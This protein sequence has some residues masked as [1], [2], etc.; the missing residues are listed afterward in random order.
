MAL[1]IATENPT[2]SI[3]TSAAVPTPRSGGIDSCPVIKD[4]TPVA[5]SARTKGAEKA[6]NAFNTAILS[7]PPFHG[8]LFEDQTPAN[9]KTRLR[10]C[11][12][13]Q[14]ILPILPLA[15]VQ[16]AGH[17]DTPIGDSETAANLYIACSESE[18]PSTASVDTLR[19]V[20][21]LFPRGRGRK[22]ESRARQEADDCK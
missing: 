4:T 2:R 22:S 20:R 14:S 1:S 7:F 5:A 8:L 6:V 9:C 18:T 11:P 16:G 3:E 13:R 15:L 17:I 10:P 19:A 12:R 21:D